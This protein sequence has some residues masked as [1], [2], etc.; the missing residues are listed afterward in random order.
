MGSCCSCGDTTSRDRPGADHRTA[1]E[2]ASPSTARP[3]GNRR[4]DDIFF[5]AL[6][7]S[8]DVSRS[9]SRQRR[10][11]PQDATGLFSSTPGSP[12]HHDDDRPQHSQ[13]GGSS[14]STCTFSNTFSCTSHSR[15]NPF[16]APKSD[17]CERVGVEQQGVS[18]PPHCDEDHPNS[19]T[20]SSIAALQRQRKLS[21]GSSD[22]A[23][24]GHAKL[25]NVSSFS[26]RTVVTVATADTDSLSLPPNGEEPPAAF[27]NT[28]PGGHR[29]SYS[30]SQGGSCGSARRLFQRIKESSQS[31]KSYSS[32][33]S[34]HPPSLEP[35]GVF[36]ESE[37]QS[38]R[39]G[40]LS[41]R[42]SSHH[43]RDATNATDVQLHS[44]SSEVGIHS[45][46]AEEVRHALFQM[47]QPST[48]TIGIS[49]HRGRGT[50][51]THH[52][53]GLLTHAVDPG[54]FQPTSEMVGEM[55]DVKSNSSSST[56]SSR[57][58][59]LSQL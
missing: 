31:G 46:N 32:V 40:K 37:S 27:R 47:V 51:V 39:G 29:N 2:C 53:G 9:S 16:S 57:R 48:P 22:G 8:A 33:V 56:H 11:Q 34:P 55:V 38:S 42:S 6:P 12:L 59:S 45:S 15:R 7:T 24:C 41:A 25:P 26:N 5:V 1:S 19:S 44:A 23:F 18:T 17:E 43:Q 52:Q 13:R 14:I 4:A 20:A 58:S 50:S 10:A 49:E 30:A 28:N 3:T 21:S 35:L 54:L 36:S